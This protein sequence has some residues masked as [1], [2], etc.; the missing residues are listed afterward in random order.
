[1]LYSKFIFHAKEKTI[2]KLDN[3][4]WYLEPEWKDII[5]REIVDDI[6]K[7]E[8]SYISNWDEVKDILV[9]EVSRRNAQDSRKQDV[10]NWLADLITTTAD[11]AMLEAETNYA[12]TMIEFLKASGEQ[13]NI[14]PE[15]D[16]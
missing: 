3:D 13:D 5:C 4:V 10:I 7:L 12:K 11:P 9:L 15:G 16:E 1:M 6:T 2:Q 14:I 8:D